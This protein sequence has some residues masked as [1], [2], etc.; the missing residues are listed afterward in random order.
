M[1][2]NNIEDLQVMWRQLLGEAPSDGQ[3]IVWAELYP[4]T[5]IRHAFAKTGQKNFSDPAFF[6]NLDHKIRFASKCMQASVQQ[7]AAGL[8]EWK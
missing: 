6:E 5:T 8:K 2:N 3:F 4:V 7:K 1:T